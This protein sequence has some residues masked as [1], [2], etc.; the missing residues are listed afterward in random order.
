[1]AEEEQTEKKSEQ[2][3]TAEQQGRDTRKTI[4]GD[5]RTVPPFVT[6]PDPPWPMPP[7]I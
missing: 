7:M 3:Q 5:P 4:K 2:E 6:P 1:M